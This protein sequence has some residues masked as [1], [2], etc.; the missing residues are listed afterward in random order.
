M[1]NTIYFMKIIYNVIED[2]ECSQLNLRTL[3]SENPNLWNSNGTKKNYKIFKFYL[4]NLQRRFIDVVYGF[5]AFIEQ[6]C[7]YLIKLFFFQCYSNKNC[8][9]C[10]KNVSEPPNLRYSSIYY[11]YVYCLA[12]VYM[13]KRY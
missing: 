4:F 10:L 11:C 12:E 13:M 8:R 9:L 2:H 3:N 7:Y 6:N 1:N 5:F